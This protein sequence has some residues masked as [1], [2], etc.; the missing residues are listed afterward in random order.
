MQKAII[1]FIVIL[2]IMSACSTSDTSNKSQPSNETEKLTA[3][4]TSSKKVEEKPKVNKFTMTKSPVPDEYPE[5]KKLV[6]M[7]K[8]ES[9]A[10]WYLHFREWDTESGKAK[11]IDKLN[12]LKGIHLIRLE[13][14]KYDKENNT[15]II[16]KFNKKNWRDMESMLWDKEMGTFSVENIK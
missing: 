7:Y 13:V 4:K 15:K 2:V 6:A 1:I 3:P 8:N 12:R 16:D 14:L 10:Q 9:W 11:N 5:F